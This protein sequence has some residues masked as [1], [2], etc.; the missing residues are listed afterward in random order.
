MTIWK[1]S[2]LHI[3]SIIGLILGLVAW[4]TGLHGYSILLFVPVLWF[5]LPNRKTVFF[6][7]LFYYMGASKELPL[8]MYHFFEGNVLKTIFLWITQQAI[9]A[10]GWLI[11]WKKNVDRL[12]SINK[13]LLA[14]YLI[15]IFLPPY[16]FIGFAHPITSAGYF[17]PR[18]S[19]SG[20]ILLFILTCCMTYL[21]ILIKNNSV[22]P[23]FT[24]PDF[25]VTADTIITSVV[26][27]F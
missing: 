19:F 24:F 21:I 4:N 11:F 26:I 16:S 20:I 25:A 6:F 10:T 17:F 5:F 7:F 12:L 13:R 23:R 2:P 22:S 1:G 15:T 14:T 3:W 9:L 27:D 18:T 8:G